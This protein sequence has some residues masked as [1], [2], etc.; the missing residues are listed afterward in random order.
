MPD[1]LPPLPWRAAPAAILTLALATAAPAQQTGGRLGGSHHEAPSGYGSGYGY[2]AA[3]TPRAAAPGPLIVQSLRDG[4]AFCSRL[5]DPTYQVDCL[6]DYFDWVQGRWA[7]VGAYGDALDTLAVT[8]ARLKQVRDR[9]ADP[10][11]RG[12]RSFATAG[13]GP[14]THRAIRPVA[15]AA[16]AAAARAAAQVIA[17]AETVLLRSARGQPAEVAGQIRLIAAAVGSNK[18]L[19]RST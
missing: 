7:H 19:L 2:R 17:E 3:P 18:V 1:I 13:G 16:S 10:A 15:P 5:P 14:E 8:A 4:A 9:F 6:A 12:G 11:R